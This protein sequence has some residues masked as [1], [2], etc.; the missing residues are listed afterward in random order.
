MTKY[1]DKLSEL[2]T[3][4]LVRKDILIQ[5]WRS[6]R[7]FYLH[8]FAVTLLWYVAVQSSFLHWNSITWGV[9]HVVYTNH[10][11]EEDLTKLKSSS[12]KTDRK[13]KVA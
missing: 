12:P 1:E 13:Q 9:Q 8:C 10:K 7:N 5:K 11:L 6:E 4:G 3:D 2:H